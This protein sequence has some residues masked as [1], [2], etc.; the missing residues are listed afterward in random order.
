MS[1]KDVTEKHKNGTYAM[2]KVSKKSQDQIEKWVQDTLGLKTYIDPS[3]YHITI[4]YS[5]KPVPLAETEAGKR[6]MTATPIGLTVFETKI[7]KEKYCLVLKVESE[8]ARKIHEKL[9]KAGAT[10]D[11]PTYTPH[12]TLLYTNDKPDFEE[13][14]IPK[15]DIELDEIEVSGLDEEI[16]IKTKD[17]K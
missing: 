7:M 14:L 1:F 9:I 6:D 2:A 15:F 4:C 8:Q 17:V 13:S 3:E 5:R 11:Y 12:I 16:T 10:F